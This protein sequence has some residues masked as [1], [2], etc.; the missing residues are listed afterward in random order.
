MYTVCT[1]RPRRCPS[2]GSCMARWWIPTQYGMTSPTK[3]RKPRCACPPCARPWSVTTLKRPWGFL[4][5]VARAR[6]STASNWAPSARSLGCSPRA[7]ASPCACLVL[8]WRTTPSSVHRPG[9]GW[10]ARRPFLCPQAMTTP[11]M[12]LHWKK[13]CARVSKKA[14]ALPPSSSPWAVPTLL[15]W[16][17]SRLCMRC[18]CAWSRST[19]LT[20]CL[21][22]MLML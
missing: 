19:A 2:S 22:S 9:W 10:V 5:L 15:A 21:T 11:W 14:S 3:V 20:I 12:W 8:M 16:T 18:A 13:P 6:R 1:V 4:P 17:T 7:C